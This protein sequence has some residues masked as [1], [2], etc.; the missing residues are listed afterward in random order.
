MTT[1]VD[2]A[3]LRELSEMHVSVHP[4]NKLYFVHVVQTGPS[5]VANR[6]S[7]C[8][9]LERPRSSSLHRHIATLNIVTTHCRDCCYSALL[10]VSAYWV[11][12]L[13]PLLWLGWPCAAPQLPLLGVLRPIPFG[14]GVICESFFFGVTAC[15][16]YACMATRMTLCTTG[17]P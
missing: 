15:A 2:Q 4:F 7:R 10:S 12:L 9:V 16:A 3:G 5:G 11:V 14:V 1:S 17:I 6:I 8:I 13:A